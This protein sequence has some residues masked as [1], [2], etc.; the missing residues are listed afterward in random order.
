M[1]KI[2]RC[3]T[4]NREMFG[5]FRTRECMP[6]ALEEITAAFGMHVKDHI[7]VATSQ[8]CM[9]DDAADQMA[10]IARRLCGYEPCLAERGEVVGEAV[11]LRGA[12]LDK[13]SAH[14]AVSVVCIGMQLIEAVGET[15][16]GR[17]QMMM[18]IDDR[19]IGVDHLFSGQVE[20]LLGSRCGHPAIIPPAV[21]VLVPIHPRGEICLED[22][23]IVAL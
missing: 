9:G 13:D 14:D 7:Q 10:R 22:G 4:S 23:R 20:P 16:A 17:P 11:I 12:A 6:D 18:R 8:I 2:A 21:P 5:V 19:P 15:F 1:G 3:A